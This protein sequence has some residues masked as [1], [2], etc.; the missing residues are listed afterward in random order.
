[1]IILAVAA[2]I[3]IIVVAYMK[4]GWFRAGVNAAIGGVVAAWNWLKNMTASAIATSIAWILRLVTWAQRAPGQ[5][6]AGFSAVYHS[7]VDPIANAVNWAINRLN[8][9]VNFAANIPGRVGGAVSGA[10]SSAWNSVTSHLPHIPG[11]ASGG[12]VGAATGGARGGLVQVGEHGR[13]LVRLPAGS[14]VIPNGKTEQIMGE[15]GG[16]GVG[17]FELVSDGSPEMDFLLAW[18]RKVI[19]VRGGNVQLVLGS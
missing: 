18:L 6:S 13:E 4:V 15:G 12:I 17:R 3:A 16:G 19:R 2:F 11:F 5:I 8:D 7:I 9:L 10:A 1:L 14:S